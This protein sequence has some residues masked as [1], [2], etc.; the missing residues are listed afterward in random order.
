M[1]ADEAV[2]AGFKVLSRIAL[3]GTRFASVASMRSPLERRFLQHLPE[4][5]LAVLVPALSI[6]VAAPDAMTTILAIGVAVAWCML[7]IPAVIACLIITVM[8]R[9]KSRSQPNL[10]A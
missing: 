10:R 1:R 4:V 3:Q 2:S 6:A 9:P 7:L 5:Y 8:K